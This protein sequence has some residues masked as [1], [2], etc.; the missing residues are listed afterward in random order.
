MSGLFGNLANGVKALNAQSIGLQTAGRNLANVN[1][2]S[3]ARQRVVFGDRGTVVTPLGPQSL[4]VEALAVTQIRDALLDQQVVREIATTADLE[5]IQSGLQKAQAGLG[6]SV[7]SATSTTTGVNGI[8]E[9]MTEFFNSFK[10]YAATPTDVGEKQTLIQ[11]AGILVDRI[12]L[13]DSRL[14]QTQSDLTTLAQSDVTEVNTILQQIADLNIQIGRLEV[15]APGS[16]VDLRDSRQAKLEELATKISFE[17]RYTPGAN[18]QIEVYARDASNNEVT[19]VEMSTVTTLSLNGST[20][21]AGPNA[22]DPALALSGGSIKGAIQTRDGAIQDLR[23]SL[24][25]L[26]NQ[27]VTSVNAT[28]NPSSTAGRNFFNAAGVD[29]SSIK[30]ETGLT[31]ST[32][33]ASDSGVAGDNDIASA[34]ANLVSKVFSTAGGDHIDGTFGQYYTNAVTGLGQSLSTVNSQLTD[35]QKIEDLVTQQRDGVSGVSLDEETADLM[36]YQ[37]AFE[38]CSRV[39]SAID[40]MLDTIVNRMGA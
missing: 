16:A 34:V 8:A 29:A 5:T 12:N 23:D 31:A 20:L 6:Q 7:Q 2:A 32:L 15:S 14:V 13:T 10:S 38:A 33:V 3:Y 35:Q 26:A 21:N 36:K 9:T 11:Q 22:T 39:I 25:E 30:L 18:G 19:L 40:E 37:R 4:G 1:N 27:L 17:T 24:D 28:Y